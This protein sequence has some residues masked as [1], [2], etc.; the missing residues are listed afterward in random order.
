MFSANGVAPVSEQ[1][2]LLVNR[3]ERCFVENEGEGGGN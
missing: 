2:L 3:L 1:W